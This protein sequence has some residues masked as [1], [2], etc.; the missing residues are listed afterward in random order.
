MVKLERAEIGGMK[1]RGNEQKMDV[2]V[3]TMINILL[4]MSL[5]WWG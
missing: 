1:E 3:E 2:L 4:S 5:S